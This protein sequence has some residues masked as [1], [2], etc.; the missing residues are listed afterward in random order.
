MYLD[1]FFILSFFATTKEILKPFYEDYKESNDLCT[2]QALDFYYWLIP[3]FLQAAD[4]TTMMY[5]IEGRT[6][7]LDLEVYKVANKIYI[8]P[9]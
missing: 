7:F 6:P 9:N 1:L 3:D 8:I 4:R 2:R 5:G